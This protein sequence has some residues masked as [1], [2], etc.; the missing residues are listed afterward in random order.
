MA[1]E[2]KIANLF[3]QGTRLLDRAQSE[4]QDQALQ[5]L[6]LAEEKFTAALSYAPDLAE[7]ELNQAIALLRQGDR[8]TDGQTRFDQYGRALQSLHAYLQHTKPAVMPLTLSGYCLL[9]QAKLTGGEA[10]TALLL[11]ATQ[12]FLQAES[13]SA[14]S[15]TYNLACCAAL[16]GDE[17][18]CRKWLESA[19]EAGVLPDYDHVAKD[20]DLT[21][22]SHFDWFR[23]FLQRATPIS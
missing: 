11:E 12:M 17:E 15:G 1:S 13:L 6:R 18:N 20:Q 19:L 16:L 21:A 2:K 7:A 14:G 22:V 5:L 3:R 23:E 8:S 9:E 4:S 10:R